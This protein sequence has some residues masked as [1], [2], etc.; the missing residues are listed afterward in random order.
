M[1]VGDGESDVE[2][3]KLAPVVFARSTLLERLDGRHERLY[4]FETFED[5]RNVLEREGAGWLESF[6]SM[7]AAEG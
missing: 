4:A 3:A 5:V 6:S 7:T 2:A 1:Y